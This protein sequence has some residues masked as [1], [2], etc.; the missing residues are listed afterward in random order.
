MILDFLLVRDVVLQELC[1]A[2]HLFDGIS[3]RGV[4]VEFLEH[5]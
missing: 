4:D 5:I 1:I 3:E 2:Q